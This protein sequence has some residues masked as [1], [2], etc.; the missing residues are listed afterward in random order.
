ML[1]NLLGNYEVKSKYTWNTRMSSTHMDR[2]NFTG[3]IFVSNLL[4]EITIIPQGV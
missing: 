1:S 2:N 4:A 3:T